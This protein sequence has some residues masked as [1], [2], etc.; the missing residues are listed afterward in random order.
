M[1]NNTRRNF[2]KGMAIEGLGLKTNSIIPF[3]KNNNKT[4]EKLTF[5]NDVD[6]CIAGGSCTG[7]FA[8]LRASRLG[9]KV[10][11][12]EKTKLIR[13]CCHKWTGKYLALI[14]RY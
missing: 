9:T 10:D 11:I 7:V 4:D 8:A 5:L 2:I 6:I 14:V 12:I 3:Q 1:K 13:W